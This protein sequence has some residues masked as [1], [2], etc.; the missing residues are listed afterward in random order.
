MQ[1]NHRNYLPDVS[2]SDCHAVIGVATS[3]DAF[4]LSGIDFAN[5]DAVE[6]ALFGS[7]L[8][9][10]VPRETIELM[11]R[12]GHA[13]E[14]FP[15]CVMDEN[16]P[17]VVALRDWIEPSIDDLWEE[18]DLETRALLIAARGVYATDKTR[19]DLI[20]SVKDAGIFGALAQALLQ[21]PMTIR[22]KRPSWVPPVPA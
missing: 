12:A 18:E 7:L 15:N 11:C 5:P 17:Q 4:D 21:E 16:H 19:R 10:I 22:R 14:L 9:D 8:G 2:A 3:L 1:P 6:K 20:L 13:R